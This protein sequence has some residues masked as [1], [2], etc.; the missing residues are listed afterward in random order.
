MYYELWPGTNMEGKSW[1]IEG[2]KKR[3]TVLK[4]KASRRT[5]NR[6]HIYTSAQKFSIQYIDTDWKKK[7]TS[8]LPSM[9][10]ESM[11]S[12]EDWEDGSGRQ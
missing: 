9:D 11:K 12:R 6:G 5:R 4:A 1:Q 8:E 7:V 2:Q 10:I 3:I